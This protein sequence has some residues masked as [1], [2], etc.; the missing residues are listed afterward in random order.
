[1]KNLKKTYIIIIL[2]F[3][4]LVLS[5]WYLL[6]NVILADQIVINSFITAAV[7]LAFGAYYITRKRWGV[8]VFMFA[9]SGAIIWITL[10]L[11]VWG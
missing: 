9:V 5:V 6:T 3:T 7:P 10:K 2:I 1:M 11:F 4:V 8:S